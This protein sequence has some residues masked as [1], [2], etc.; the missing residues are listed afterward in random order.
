[1][2]NEL[3]QGAVIRYP[4]LWGSQQDTGETEGRKTRPACVVLRLPDTETQIHHLIILAISS[5]PP[6]EHQRSLE[7]P[8]IERQR[9]GL[10]RYPRAWV[11]VSEYN[12]D[13]EERSW[14]YAPGAKRLGTFSAKFL[15][16]IATAAEPVFTKR[17]ARVDRTT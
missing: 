5:K 6:L 12:Y 3:T 1:M 2:T 14:Y 10:S 8:D 17:S 15:R 13:I 7:I 11:I 16:Q 9:A 4:Y